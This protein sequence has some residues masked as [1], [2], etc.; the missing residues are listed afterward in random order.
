MLQKLKSNGWL[1]FFSIILVFSPILRFSWDFATQ[2]VF[3]VLILSAFLISINYYKIPFTFKREGTALLF[4]FSALLPLIGAPELAQVRNELLVLLDSLI[5]AYLVRFLSDEQKK[6]LFK[7]PILAGFCLSLILL[8]YFLKAPQNYFTG[9]MLQ[10]EYLINPNIIAGY[11]LLSFL[12]AFS[13]WDNLDDRNK[14]LFKLL[15]LII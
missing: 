7:I 15:T 13:Y 3:H 11:L 10:Y 4:F 1:I 2:C 14:V 6:Q 8:F 9:G 12:L 5:L